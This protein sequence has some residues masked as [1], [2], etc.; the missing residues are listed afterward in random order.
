MDQRGG[1]KRLRHRLVERLRAVEDHQQTALGAQPATLQV[2]QE[3][4]THGRVFAMA[5][6]EQVD[7]GKLTL[8]QGVHVAAGDL[9]PDTFN[10]LR[11]RYPLGNV[12]LTLSELLRFTV[13]QSDNNGCDMLF[14]MLGGTKTV[15]AYVRGLGVSAVAIAATKIGMPR[16]HDL[17][18]TTWSEPAGMLQLLDLFQRGKVHQ[19]TSREFLLRLMTETETGPRR[20]KGLLPPDTVVSHKTGTSSTDEKGVTAASH[21]VGIVTL[22]NGRHVAMVVFVTDSQAAEDIRERTIAEIARAGYDYFASL[23]PTPRADRPAGR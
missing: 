12:D 3:T 22:P 6:L 21:D 1:T 4:L 19:A 14:R 2:G 7:R 23:A 18:F 16:Q 15:D 20:L 8:A 17:Q 11:D 5:V 9:Q 10:P 13:S